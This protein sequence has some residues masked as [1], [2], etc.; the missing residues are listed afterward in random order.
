MTLISVY[1][2]ETAGAA[3]GELLKVHFGDRICL[4]YYAPYRY[5]PFTSSM[6]RLESIPSQ[7]DCLHG[8]FLARR[9]LDLIHDSRLVTWLRDPVERVISE[10]E[11]LKANPDSQ[12]GLS[13]LISGGASLLD[14]AENEYARNTQ[15][16]YVDGV[17]LSQFAFVGVSERFEKELSRFAD[18]TG[19]CLLDEDKVDAGAKWRRS[20]PIDGGLRKR[21]LDLNQEDFAL[22]KAAEE[23]RQSQHPPL[24]S[25]PTSNAIRCSPLDCR[26]PSW[27]MPR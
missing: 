18:L 23:S 7:I 15:A 11:F 16:R 25:L 26:I 14:F 17:P 24:W 6:V 27:K 20:H 2:P 19:I 8:H 10:Y 4:H 3:F 13:R 9:F 5:D 1:I 12:S 22:Y 21:L